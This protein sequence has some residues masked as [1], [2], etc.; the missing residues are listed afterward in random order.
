[1]KEQKSVIQSND[2]KIELEEQKKV[3][4]DRLNQIKYLY[5]D[6]E[7]LKKQFEK[8]KIQ[9]IKLANE[10]LIKELLTIL[11]DIESSLK[12]IIEKKDKE[13]MQ[14]IH[15][16]LIGILKNHGVKEIES[17]GNKMDFEKHDVVLKEESDKEEG[18]IIEEIQKGYILKSKVIRHS[19]VKV[20]EKFKNVNKKNIIGEEKNG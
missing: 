7:N 2:L 19:K 14:K 18:V 1:M 20:S 16:K 6:F 13:G 4:E 10:Y 9:I 17:V 8:E 3:S 12:L 11:D 5:A 15:D